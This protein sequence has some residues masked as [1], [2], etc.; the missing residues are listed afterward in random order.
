MA[1]PLCVVRFF[2]RDWTRTSGFTVETGRFRVRM[3]V[4]LHNNGPVTFLQNGRRTCR[5][6]TV[7]TGGLVSYQRDRDP[8]RPLTAA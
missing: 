1:G 7:G 3:I 8:C 5:L 4:A 6:S 2:F